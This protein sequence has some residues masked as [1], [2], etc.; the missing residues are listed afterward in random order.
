MAQITAQQVTEERM[1]EGLE[2]YPAGDYLVVIDESDYKL[3]KASDMERLSLRYQM[4]DGPF[5]GKIY[6][7]G[8]NLKNLVPSDDNKNQSVN[9]SWRQYNSLKDALGVTNPPDS[10]VLHNI[11]FYLKLGVKKDK[12]TEEMKNIVKGY[13]PAKY[14]NNSPAPAQGDSKPASSDVKKPWERK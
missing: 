5:K 13:S 8:F 7:D 2:L 4:I 14:Q 10:E 1:S 6:Y 11:P 3:T 9:I 12:Q